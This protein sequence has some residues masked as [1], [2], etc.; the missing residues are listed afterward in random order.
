MLRVSVVEGRDKGR[1][2]VCTEGVLRL[3]SAAGN[4]LMLTD[5]FVSG[6]HGE[7]ALVGTRWIYRDLGSTNGSA[8]ERAGEREA[9]PP[10][11]AGK[12][13]AD[14]DVLR[15]GQSALQLQLLDVPPVEVPDTQV[16]ASRSRGDIGASMAQAQRMSGLS[17]GVQP[18]GEIGVAFDP[19]AM[20]DAILEA[21]L[22]AFPAGTHAIILLADRKT[23][24]P[25][26][27]IARVRGQVGRCQEELP[28]SMSIAR[29]VLE[30]GHSL[31][32]QDVPKEFKDS[33]S[34]VAAAITSSICAPLWTGEETVGLIQ[35]EAR[36][37]RGRFTEGDLE[38]LAVF[39]GRAALAI[40]GSEL[41]DAE[42]KNQLIRDLSDM[43]A[44][45]LKGPLTTVMGFLEL[46]AEEPLEGR[47]KQY[48]E[49]S[50]GAA[51]WLSVLV[52][53]ILDVARLEGAEVKLAREPLDLAE[54]I[55]AA[56][57][58]INYQVSDKGIQVVIEPGQQCGGI[59]ALRHQPDGVGGGRS[60]G[61]VRDRERPGRGPGHP[62]GVPG[63]H[64]RQV[65]PGQHAGAD[66]H[67]GE[68]GA[69]AVVLPGGARREDLGGKRAGQ[70]IPVPLLAAGGRAQGGRV[71]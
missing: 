37:R 55:P 34:V 35:V 66:T 52:A 60:R 7:L 23:L 24:Q 44:H 36:G 54:E 18:A 46:L 32:F 1:M 57:D 31:L 67:Q 21:A 38:Q 64:L 40:V 65:L 19:E 30:E 16:L 69:G 48:V 68:R 2:V 70:G 3:G 10:G 58:L 61:R 42:R 39:A 25:K 17:V 51:R 43:V 27:Q 47:A 59:G 63:A 49:R 71:R 9:V 50:L 33:E 14:G 28:I 56:L 4:D 53:G 6:R 45:D 8:I 29:R 11:E 12:E 41:A 62:Q 13:I 15:V 22:N 5:P 20:L 26:R